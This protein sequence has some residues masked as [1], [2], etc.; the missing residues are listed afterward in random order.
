MP[1]GTDEDEELLRR[2]YA[3]AYHWQRAGS[4]SPA[5]QARASYLVARALIAT[6][7]AERGLVSAERCLAQ[8]ERHRLA[9]FDLAYAHEARARALAAL[10]RSTEAT[11][12]AAAARAVPIA[13]PED[14][15]LVEQ[16]F[17]DLP[18]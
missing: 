3:A 13:D 9:D 6:G 16:D 2:A 17:A 12:A 5:N 7:Q 11:D 1:R 15:A 4:A 18:G 10:G 14:L 8:C